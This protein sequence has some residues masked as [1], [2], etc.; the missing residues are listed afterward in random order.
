MLPVATHS[1]HLSIATGG[2]NN[3]RLLTCARTRCTRS[4]TP[5]Q[6]RCTP[7]ETT[8]TRIC[9]F[10]VEK[11]HV[12]STRQISYLITSLLFVKLPQ[13]NIYTN[14]CTTF[15]SNWAVPPFP[16]TESNRILLITTAFRF[17]VTL[18]HHGSIML[19]LFQ[20]MQE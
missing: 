10:L 18:H 9:Q 4:S 14:I 2:N 7:S 3:T 13:V 19:F 12:I 6:T 15:F 16:T 11:R 8:F 20:E 5:S 17:S 1:F